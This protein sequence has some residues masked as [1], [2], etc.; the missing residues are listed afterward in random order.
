MPKVSLTDAVVTRYKAKP[1]DRIDYFD[2]LLGHGFALRVSG[3]TPHKPDGRKSRVL[4]YHFNGALK[5]MTIKPGYPALGLA[6]AREQ[7]RTALQSLAEGG[8][9][10]AGKREAKAARERTPAGARPLDPC[11]PS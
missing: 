7:A 9:P 2:T 8:D 3:P 5:R 6:E 1:G 4:F 11:R 10:A